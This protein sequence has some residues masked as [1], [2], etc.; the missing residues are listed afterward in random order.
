MNRFIM[1]CISKPSI[2]HLQS[3]IYFELHQHIHDAINEAGIKTPSPH[4]MDARD[5]HLLDVH[6]ECYPPDYKWPGLKNYWDK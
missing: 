1:H 6:R 2:P 5:G 3:K 4:W